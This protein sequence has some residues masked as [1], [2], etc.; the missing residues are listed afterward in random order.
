M[1]GSLQ[2]NEALSI[3]YNRL[4]VIMFM[5]IVFAILLLVLKKTT[6]GLKVRAVAQNRAMAKS[7]GR[8]HGVGR[9]A[10]VRSGLRHRGRRRRR[11]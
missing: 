2:I 8:A 5:L 9:C 1:A 7:D 11:A 10:D 4:Y 6:L 3:T